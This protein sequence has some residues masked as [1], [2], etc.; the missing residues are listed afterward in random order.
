MSENEQLKHYKLGDEKSVFYIQD[1]ITAK[2]HEELI[3][4]IYNQEEVKWTQLSNRR[5]QN[6]GGIPHEKGMIAYPLPKWLSSVSNDLVKQWKVFGEERY[7][8]HVL[9]NE[10]ESQ[11]GIMAH[12]DGPVYEPI[13]C[14]L[15]L[16]SGIIISF[17]KE[18]EKEHSFSVY[19]EPRSMLIFTEDIF[20]KYLHDID[21]QDHIHINQ[22]QNIL[23]LDQLEDIKI[24][25]VIP[26]KRRI[27]L[28]YRIVKKTIN[29]S[30]WIRL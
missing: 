26:R 10:Y 4:N 7:P 15:S 13:V 19:L 1:F 14:I 21:F 8:N 30:K 20:D 2:E 6:H 29:K 27:S 12:K 23:N 5:L 24:G 28:T 16:E 3:K 11:Q 17:R 25:D 22:E 9:I 18:D